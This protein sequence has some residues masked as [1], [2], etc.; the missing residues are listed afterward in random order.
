MVQEFKNCN[1]PVI[2]P[3]DDFDDDNG[4][5]HLPPIGG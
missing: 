2:P 3:D 1:D 5:P 4:Q